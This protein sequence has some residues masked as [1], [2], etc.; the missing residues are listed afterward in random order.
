MKKNF[1]KLL[2]GGAL[3]CGL[4]MSLTSC[5]DILGH[6]EKPVPNTVTPGGGSDGG[7]SSTVSVTSITL[8]KTSTAL[9]I[10][11]TETLTV[12]TI[13]PDD[14]TNKTVTWSSDKDAVATVDANGL[15]TAVAVGTAIITATANDGS[16][17]TGTCS[18]S[19]STTGLLTGD[20]SVAADKKVRFSRGNLQATCTSTDGDASTQETWTWGF[21]ANQWDYVGNAAANNAIDGNGSV[22]TAGTVDLF[23]WVGASNTSWGGGAQYGI[24]NTKT[25]G[26]AT[27]FGTTAG[28]SLKADWGS[29]M[30]T[31][32]RTLT[33]AEWDYLFN[34]RSASTIGTTENAR[35]VRAKLLGSKSGIILFP[36]NYTHP[37]GVTV[38]IK[39]NENGSTDYS[40]NN[41]D[42][43][44][45][46]K[47]ETAGAVFLPTTGKWAMGAGSAWYVMNLDNGYYWSATSSSSNA[48]IAKQ[49]VFR[50]S[51]LNSQ[52][53]EDRC[54]RCAVRLVYDVK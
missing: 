4:S 43:A 23:G 22:S 27:D 2:L 19:V 17:V 51:D 45:W 29:T 8:N 47:M 14:A 12:T 11:A 28:E 15:V 18:V 44:A 7:G 1:S 21:A 33:S 40:N 13:A 24:S 34:T 20:F 48:G 9:L 39:I 36:D 38:P 53:D 16:G 41:Y 50:Q 10:G 46:T 32:W 42:A 35:F 54:D 31:G 37:D 26:S 30:G 52:Y 5:E 3:L 49:L 6:W 25:V